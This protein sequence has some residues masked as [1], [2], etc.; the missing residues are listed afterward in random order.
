MKEV[1]C[2]QPSYVM[3]PVSAAPTEFQVGTAPLG[4][5][6][7][8]IGSGTEPGLCGAPHNPGADG[9]TYPPRSEIPTRGLPRTPA[10]SLPGT[11]DQRPPHSPRCASQPPR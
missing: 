1:V 9:E 5:P 2:S 8:I 6:G 3:C 11:P 10:A 7:H 4:T